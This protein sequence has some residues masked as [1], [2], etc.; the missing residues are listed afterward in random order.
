MGALAVAFQPLF[1]FIS[2]GVNPDALLFAASSA[3]FLCLARGFRRGLTRRLAAAT[4]A[5]IGLGFLTKL[6]FAGLLPGALAGL[7]VLGVRGERARSLRALRLPAIAVGVAA[8]P[9]ALLLLAN[10]LVW[11][12]SSTGATT[13]AF[14]PTDRGRLARRRARA[15]S[16]SSMSCTF[17]ARRGRCGPTSRCATYGSRASSASSAG[18]TRHSAAGSTTPGRPSSPCSLR[19]PASRSRAL[20]RRC[21]GAARRCSSTRRCPAACCS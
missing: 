18:S 17:R 20:A 9:I 3:L 13:G 8:V 4:G 1:A 6:N 21:D 12:R 7:I 16:R 15:T 11:D 2:G 14:R 10:V 5:V 19:W